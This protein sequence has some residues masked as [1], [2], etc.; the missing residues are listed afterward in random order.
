MRKKPKKNKRLLAACCNTLLGSLVLIA[1]QVFFQQ[2]AHSADTESS[3]SAFALIN[4]EKTHKTYRVR[5]GDSLLKIAKRLNT[6]DTHYYQV[7]V[8]LWLKNPTVFVSKNPNKIII[9]KHLQLPSL[10]EVN[11]YST[12]EAGRL[13]KSGQYMPPKKPKPLVTPSS[14]ES[15]SYL[16]SS[17]E[18]KPH[19][20]VDSIMKQ[21]KV[22]EQEIPPA[23]TQKQ[24]RILHLES[25]Q[26]LLLQLEDNNVKQGQ[27]AAVYQD[28][29]K[30]LLAQQKIQQIELKKRQQIYGTLKNA[31]H[32]AAFLKPQNISHI[33][34]KE[35]HSFFKQVAV[36]N[37][38]QQPLPPL[39]KKT[40]ALY[41]ATTPEKTAT[42][43][44]QLFDISAPGAAWPDEW[45]G[46]QP[47]KAV[48][49]AAT[50]DILLSAL[51]RTIQRFP[52]LTELTERVVLQWDYCA[53]TGEGAGLYDLSLQKE[54][55]AAIKAK[56]PLPYNS[57]GFKR[58]GFSQSEIA[59]AAR[60]I[61][62]LL[63]ARE[64]YHAFEIFFHRIFRQ[65]CFPH[66]NTGKVYTEIPTAERIL[67]REFPPPQEEQYGTKYPYRWQPLCDIPQVNYQA[68]SAWPPAFLKQATHQLTI[69]NKKLKVIKQKITTLKQEQQ[70]QQQSL[71]LAN[72][73][74]KQQ[75]DEAQG[76]ESERQATIE[77][78]QAEITRLKI[79]ASSKQHQSSTAVMQ[80]LAAVKKHPTEQITL[81]SAINHNFKTTSVQEFPFQT[82]GL[83]VSTLI[84]MKKFHTQ[85]VQPSISME[86]TAKEFH[87]Q[88]FTSLPPAASKIYTTRT[89]GYVDPE[90]HII[91][92]YAITE[93]TER[94][95]IYAGIIG[96]KGKKSA[97][98][99]LM[100]SRTTQTE[101]EPLGKVVIKN[102]KND[103]HV[104]NSMRKASGKTQAPDA[105]LVTTTKV[106]EKKKLES[107]AR[108][109]MK[110]THKNTLATSTEVSKFQ[111]KKPAIL[112]AHRAAK[113]T[114]L[115]HKLSQAK[116]VNFT[117]Q[118]KVATKKAH[119]QDWMVPA[120]K[121]TF[122][123]EQPS[124]QKRTKNKTSSKSKKTVA[125]KKKL[126]ITA[127]GL[128]TIPASGDKPFGKLSVSWKPK[129]NWFV[130]GAV[131]YLK[132]EDFT[133]SWGVGYSDWRPGTTSVQLNN[134]GPVKSGEGLDIDDAIFSISHK[135]DSEWL[136]DNKLSLNLG[137]SKPISGDAAFNAT[138]QWNPIKNWYFRT[139]ASQKL[140]GGPTKWSYGFGYFDWRAE[141]WR[142]E[143]SNYENNRYP[144]D[145]FREGAVTINR[146]WEF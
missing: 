116:K 143:Y 146:A 53:I 88:I 52:S 124:K 71:Q 94:R 64:P 142:V 82:W 59:D 56:L 134:W 58:W 103:N 111:N 62:Q 66:P 91:E 118:P 57:A 1:S 97:S 65:H 19:S 36:R 140:S 49:H 99:P 18:Q 100:H 13:I 78:K 131:K 15:D 55:L 117:V 67:S 27:A 92:K 126:G 93:E 130:R 125:K 44:K 129:T 29:L 83:P 43:L 132:D 115:Q 133:Y 138:F 80:T 105:S 121:I 112:N 139:I 8:A 76:L 81:E 68:R 98:Y 12:K 77:Q 24:A 119:S 101:N 31:A 42:V 79:L 73:A 89:N 109:L 30:S 40:E 96:A 122:N 26:D 136:R 72:E 144:F 135:V 7:A 145:N 5:R 75:I 37:R 22:L 9:N 85:T 51:H 86:T 123:K 2:P 60:H 102:L 35:Q 20:E 16:V 104:K 137:M 95:L 45:L 128:Y 23:N 108:V 34:Q 48:L 33:Q 54:E 11:A 61:P 50:L 107:K 90:Q 14:V 17:L 141:T 28:K 25:L 3:A 6:P 39:L 47:E 46:K 113:I 63:E 69:V 127:T 120:S 41:C 87:P 32:K 74:I 38:W 84:T 21:V 114:A 110:K 4:T 106:E 10:S 70:D